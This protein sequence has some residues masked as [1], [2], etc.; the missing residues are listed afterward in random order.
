MVSILNINDK[1]KILDAGVGEGVFIKSI[2]NNFSDVKIDAID[3]DKKMIEY[4]KKYFSNMKSIN[5]ICSDY[6]DTFFD[7]KYD[8]IISNPPYNKFQAIKK[9]YKYQKNFKEKYNIEISGYSNQCVYFLLKSLNE[10]SK[11]GKCCYIIPY[12]FLN[13]GYGEKVKKYIQDKNILDRIYIFD[14]NLSLFDNAITT[15]CIMLFDN[16]KNDNLLRVFK[17]NSFNEL[18][19]I[20]KPYKC[21]DLKEIP[22][23]EKWTNYF[24]NNQAESDNLKRFSNFCTIKRGIATGNNNYFILTKEKIK[25][26]GLSKYV[27]LKCI[28]KSPDIKSPIFD[29]S[30]F[31]E[32]YNNNKGVYLFNGENA[33]INNDY[34]YIEFGEKSKVNEAYLLKIKSPW[35]KIEK[36]QIAPIWVSVFSR[37]K[38]KVVRN[39][40]N[41]S[42]LTTFHSVFLNN[43]YVDFT[44]LLFCY[45]LTPISQKILYMNKRDYGDGLN[46]F[47]PND[48]NNAYC[49]DFNNITDSDIKKIN[50]IYDEM[51]KKFEEKQVEKLNDIFSKYYS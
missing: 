15:S 51:C 43:D 17:I 44:N 23:K 48:I 9:R 7:R 6:L 16:A 30:T 5:F 19:N 25:K 37:D 20:I 3:I 13:T 38:I 27:C 31:T 26:L 2:I 18:D 1:A 34:K 4:N 40:C 32:L 8:Y 46:K 14:N 39:L 29:N 21:I 41:I 28:T 12:E 22:Y 36:K 11:N 45:L 10:L 35:Y 24:F 42:N 50:S 47:E 33:T 49:I